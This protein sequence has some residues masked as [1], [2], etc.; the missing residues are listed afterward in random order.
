MLVSRKMFYDRIKPNHLLSSYCPVINW[1][2]CSS[3]IQTLGGGIQSRHVGSALLSFLQ[4]YRPLSVSNLAGHVIST[5]HCALHHPSVSPVMLGPLSRVDSLCWLAL[6]ILVLCVG[7]SSSSR[8]AGFAT[9]SEQLY[10]STVPPGSECTVGFSQHLSDLKA[11]IKRGEECSDEWMNDNQALLSA[12]HRTYGAVWLCRQASW[13]VMKRAS[14]VLTS[15][16]HITSF[17]PNSTQCSLGNCQ[18]PRARE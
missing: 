2:R 12:S 8:C 13:W 16:L 14:S 4:L 11:G 1:H 7:R 6:K 17:S 3:A 10:F 18:A 15:Q 9:V 5:P